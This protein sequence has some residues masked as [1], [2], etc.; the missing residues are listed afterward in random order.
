MS[1]KKIFAI[2]FALIAIGA[3]AYLFRDELKAAIEKF[4]G[5]LKA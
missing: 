5:S 2:V 1:N 3:A 4:K